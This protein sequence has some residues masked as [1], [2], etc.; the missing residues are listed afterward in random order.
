MA[1]ANRTTRNDQKGL[2]ILFVAIILIVLV[3][4][5][6]LLLTW[7]RWE[8]QAPNVRFDRDFRALG[9]NPSLSLVA[10]D[11]GSGLKEISV[12]LTQ[13]DQSIPLIEEHYPGPTFF[14]CWRTG[15]Q[16]PVKFEL[17]HLI[18][19]KYKVQE[20]PASLVITISDYAL[21]NFFRGNR[22]RMQHD[23]VFD[24][25]PPRLEALS[26]QHY[27]NQG[28]SECVVY[29]VSPDA[30]ICGVQAGPHFFPGYSANL[31]DPNV[32]F[33]LF[34]FAY[35][36][37][38]DSPLKIVARDAAGNEAVAGFWYKLFPKKFRHSDIKIEDSFLQKA[39][40][41]IMSH[42]P[43]IK[44]QGDLVKTF[45]EINSGLRRLNHAT[46]AQLALKS[47][48]R[49]LWD[50]A[51]LQLSNS[52]VESLFAD[53]RTYF[54]QGKEID[55]QDHV[56]FDLSV[57]QQYPVEAS[58][59]GVVLYADYF[60]IYGNCVIIDHGCGLLSLYGHLSSINV[61]VGQSVKKKE[62]LGRSGATGLAAGDHL[63][64]SLFLQGVPVNPTEWWDAKWI[65]DHI[66]ERLKVTSGNAGSS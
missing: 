12:T 9:R 46:I 3:F 64:F 20:G 22:T 44:D 40:P 30:E 11:P 39:V 2:G 62:V 13:K 7:R 61:K 8:G 49:F 5:F 45:V 14:T 50:G 35:D 21:R 58:N 6:T 65:K 63:H 57:V 51:F 19:E 26:G 24:L 36:L 29:R 59:D 23:F 16:R 31:S 47:A 66:L 56:G 27:I 15:N 55:H 10:E 34:A 54:Y 53:H 33:S 42:S 25:Y 1:K 38:A 4:I 28:G 41:E 60:G 52:K 37:P 43:E 48:P 18:T 17:G 32:K